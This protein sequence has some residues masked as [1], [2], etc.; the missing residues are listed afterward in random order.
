MRTKQQLSTCCGRASG[1]GWRL[2]TDV[3]IYSD[4]Q[5]RAFAPPSPSRVG[6]RYGSRQGGGMAHNPAAITY[7]VQLD[8]EPEGGFIV[9]FPDFFLDGHSGGYSCGDTREEAL[10]QAGDL[11]ETI[12]ANHLAEGWEVPPPSPARGRPLVPLDPL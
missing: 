4:D 12:V 7:P 11:L 8:P 1:V 9:S 2:S 5:P 6:G 10:T 3:L